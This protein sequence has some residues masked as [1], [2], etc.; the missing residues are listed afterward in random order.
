MMFASAWD[1]LSDYN[2]SLNNQIYVLTRVVLTLI[3][4]SQ[5]YFPTGFFLY[6]CEKIM[7]KLLLTKYSLVI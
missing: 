3:F 6:K 4:N 2:Y 5:N 1:L 7:F